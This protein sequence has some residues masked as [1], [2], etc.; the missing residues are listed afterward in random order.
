MTFKKKKGY[1][2]IPGGVEYTRP[3]YSKI[4]KFLGCV[5]VLALLG[6]ALYVVSA[7]GMLAI[8]KIGGY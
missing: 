6:G 1:E 4:D 2:I 3:P 8:Y 5:F 7:L